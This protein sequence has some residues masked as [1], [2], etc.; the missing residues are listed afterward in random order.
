MNISHA[1]AKRTGASAAIICCHKAIN[2]FEQRIWVCSSLGS[3]Y[4][5]TPLFRVSGH[6]VFPF[7]FKLKKF[8][9]I[10]LLLL[11]SNPTST[12][13]SG[14]WTVAMQLVLKPQ[15]SLQW[16]ALQRANSNDGDDDFPS[17]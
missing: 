10:P 6:K 4:A 15:Q 14:L 17:V 16:L 13:V 11:D 2:H 5:I 9:L 1:F 7:C 12:S 8:N 3:G